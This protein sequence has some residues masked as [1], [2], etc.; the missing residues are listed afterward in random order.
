M[1]KDG[2]LVEVSM[3]CSVYCRSETH[4]LLDAQTAEVCLQNLK[5]GSLGGITQHR[6]DQS[7]TFL[8]NQT[9]TV[10]YF[11]YLFEV[12]SEPKT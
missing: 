5:C 1:N 8:T 11:Q 6:E 7:S 3:S 10:V 9:F 12:Q 4:S 2:S